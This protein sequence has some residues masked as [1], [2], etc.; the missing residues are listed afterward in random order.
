VYF[1]LDDTLSNKPLL[2]NL[3]LI[4]FQFMFT[5]NKLQSPVFNVSYV[6]VV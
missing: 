4:E 6:R 2:S 1:K 5:N 3:V